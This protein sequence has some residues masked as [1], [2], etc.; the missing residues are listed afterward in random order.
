MA[1]P[2]SGAAAAAAARG[3]CSRGLCGALAVPLLALPLVCLTAHHYG[4][5]WDEKVQRDY[6][7]LG[8]EYYRSLGADARC[9]SYLNLRWYTPAY[10]A[11][12]LCE[13]FCF[14]VVC[15]VLFCFLQVCFHILFC[16]CFYVLFFVCM[17]FY[18]IYVALVFYC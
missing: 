16:K 11:L 5:S 9:N 13:E 18:N 15:Q 10:E 4:V 12:L 6:G 2:S 1:A 3:H 17:C 8:W 14:S 7:V